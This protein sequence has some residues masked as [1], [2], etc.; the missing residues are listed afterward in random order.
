[1]W[2]KH[3]A[4]FVVEAIWLPPKELSKRTGIPTQTLANERH[5]GRGFPYTKRGKSVL[6]FWPDVHAEL[7][8]RK[9]F[10]RDIFPTEVEA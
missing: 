4:R 8:A 3:S 2:Q 7:Q 1:M 9:I 10:P 5:L 6:Y